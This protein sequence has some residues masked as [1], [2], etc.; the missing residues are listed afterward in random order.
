MRT[1]GGCG[2][3]VK[4]EALDTEIRQQGILSGNYQCGCDFHESSFFPREM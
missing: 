1:E 2:S 4:Y 3:S